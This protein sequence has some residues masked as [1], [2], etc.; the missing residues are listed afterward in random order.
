MPEEEEELDQVECGGHGGIV[1]AGAC[2]GNSTAVPLGALLD[3]GCRI[4]GMDKIEEILEKRR[5]DYH[6]PNFCFNCNGSGY[7]AKP[8]GEWNDGEHEYHAC[9]R[10]TGPSKKCIECDGTGKRK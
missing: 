1:A 2:E 7:V 4:G 9:P 6:Q 8:I 3:T 5:R 10:S